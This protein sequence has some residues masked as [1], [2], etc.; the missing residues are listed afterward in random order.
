MDA[1]E[2]AVREALRVDRPAVLD[3]LVDPA[4]YHTQTHLPRENR[5]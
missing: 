2:P 3:V 4:E 5:G 1:L